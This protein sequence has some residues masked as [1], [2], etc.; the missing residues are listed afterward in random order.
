[1][2]VNHLEISDDIL[3]INLVQ[4]IIFFL[5]RCTTLFVCENN[6]A[7]MFLISNNVK[8]YTYHQLLWEKLKNKIK[9]PLL[10]V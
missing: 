5:L 4:Y 8:M 9:I 10:H 6:K 2:Y 7:N 3:V 1:M